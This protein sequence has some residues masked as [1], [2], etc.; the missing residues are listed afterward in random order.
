MILPCS[1]LFHETSSLHSMQREGPAAL[2]SL[3]SLPVL[4]LTEL[5]PHNG[6]YP[7]GASISGV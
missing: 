4:L 1:T 3:F 6:D 5:N 2:L 7:F